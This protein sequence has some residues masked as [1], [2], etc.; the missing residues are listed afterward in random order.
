MKDRYTGKSRG[1]GFVTFVFSADAMGVAAMEH[2]VDGR[3]CEAKFALPRGGA[4][5]F[6]HALN[7]GLL[8]AGSE[9]TD[10]VT[11]QHHGAMSGPR[12]SFDCQ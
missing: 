4:M 7:A 2:H 12:L 3:R 1:F 10:V 11:M 5:A 9:G 8:S 6:K